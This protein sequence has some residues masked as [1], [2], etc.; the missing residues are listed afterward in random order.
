MSDGTLIIQTLLYKVQCNPLHVPYVQSD[1]F[2]WGSFPGEKRL[3]QGVSPADPL[4]SGGWMI[5]E[6]KRTCDCRETDVVPGN[7][8]VVDNRR[9]AIRLTAPAIGGCVPVHSPWGARLAPACQG[10]STKIAIRLSLFTS[11][12]HQSRWTLTSL[13]SQRP[14]VKRLACHATQAKLSH[15]V[16]GPFA[17]TLPQTLGMTA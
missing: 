9:P 10:S 11:M 13:N 7:E 4:R 15:D 2:C 5:G 17:R 12:P 6:A 14:P 8:Q 16:F 3:P 1:R